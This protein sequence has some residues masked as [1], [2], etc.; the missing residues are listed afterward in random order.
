DSGVIV[1][2]GGADG[3]IKT[4]KVDENEIANDRGAATASHS[5]GNAKAKKEVSL[6][7]FNFVSSDCFIGTSV[8]GEIQ[9]GWVGSQNLVE[10]GMQPH[11]S[12]EILRVEDD[13]RGY[14]VISSLP[15]RG[16]ALLGNVRGLIRLYNHENKSLV[17]IAQ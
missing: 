3:A 12:K 6:K 2:S 11:V 10:L 9:L 5:A 13:L 1:Y 14:S 17:N 15:Q 4:F 7:A 8:N 16:L